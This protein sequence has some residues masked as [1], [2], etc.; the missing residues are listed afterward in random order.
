MGI[1]KKV[2]PLFQSFGV[3]RCKRPGNFAIFAAILR[4]SSLPVAE[5]G[6]RSMEI[7]NGEL[8]SIFFGNGFCHLSSHC[9]Q[10][11]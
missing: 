11:P 4:A 9:D 3:D 7:M 1:A 2:A 10:L 6:W 5:S 8:L